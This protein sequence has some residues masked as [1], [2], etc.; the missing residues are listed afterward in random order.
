MKKLYISVLMAFCVLNAFAQSNKE[1]IDLPEGMQASTDSLYRNWLV[2]QYI[3]PTKDCGDID[4]SPVVSEEVYR[5][6]LKRIPAIIEMPYNAVVRDYIDL[7]ANRLRNRVAFMLTAKN[8]YMPMIEEALEL[9]NLPNELKYLPIIESA[10][11]PTAVSRQGAVGLWQFM[12]RTGQ[13]YGL[14]NNSLMDERR[15]PLKSSRAAARYLKD[16][17]D[18]YNDWHLAL[19]AYNC[20]PGTVNRAIKRAGGKTDFWEIYNLLPRETRGYVP[21]FIAANYIMTYYC[22]H[23]ISPMDMTMYPEG[24][25]TIHVNKNLHFRQI[26]DVCDNIDIDLLRALNPELKR[27]IIPGDTETYALRLPKSLI[28]HYMDKLA[29][30]ENSDSNAYIGRREE[31][32]IEDSTPIAVGKAT[33]KKSKSSKS[34]SHKV[35]SGENLGSIARKYGTTVAKIRKLNG[36]KGN[37]IQAGKRIRVK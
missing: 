17:Y 35:K 33:K 37:N 7:Y 8:L 30:I 16:L 25:D 3:K 23:N 14:Q 20:G 6:R 12:L 26:A 21:G 4:T 15:D 22:E 2:K 32:E 18:I 1:N 24:T 10:M 5:Q 28:N 34:V 29:V 11:N 9:Y 13:A 27:D 36:I 19:A 31:V